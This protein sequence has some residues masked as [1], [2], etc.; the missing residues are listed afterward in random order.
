VART[1][2]YIFPDPYSNLSA[3]DQIGSMVGRH[4]SHQQAMIMHVIVT[5]R[6]G[7]LAGAPKADTVDLMVAAQAESVTEFKSI[8]SSSSQSCNGHGCHAEWKAAGQLSS[9]PPTPIFANTRHFARVN[10]YFY[11]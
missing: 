1:D 7:G 9:T 2:S 3:G 5:L 8:S 4:R 11:H 10:S 6:G